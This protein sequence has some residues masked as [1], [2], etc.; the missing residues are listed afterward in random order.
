MAQAGGVVVGQKVG[1]VTIFQLTAAKFRQK[2]LR[3]AY[4][5]FQLYL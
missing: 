3:V 5:K 4:S 1:G 2:R